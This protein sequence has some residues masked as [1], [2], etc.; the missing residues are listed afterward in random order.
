[1]YQPATAASNGQG[2]QQLI[3]AMASFGAP[4]SAET[5]LPSASNDENNFDVIPFSSF[6]LVLV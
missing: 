4:T 2:T 3:Q 6:S 5:P 1:L